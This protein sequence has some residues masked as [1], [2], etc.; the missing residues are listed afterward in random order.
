MS[1]ERFRELAEAF[2][3]DPARWPPG[4]R[5]LHAQHAD[6]PTG[7][8]ILAAAAELDALLDD[9]EP[10]ADDPLRPARILR[11]AR[12]PRLGR[13]QIAWL[14]GAWAA[15]AVLGFTLGY[16]EPVVDGDTGEE[17]YAQ[18]LTGSAVLED[19]L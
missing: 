10:R 11:A 15:S 9:F 3:A 4:E 19:F 13:R 16:L 12:A 8:G 1:I 5:V 17:S 6:T 18:L 2:G 14:S 7:R